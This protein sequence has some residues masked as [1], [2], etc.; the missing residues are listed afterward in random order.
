MKQWL[1]VVFVALLFPASSLHAESRLTPVSIGVSS[2]HCMESQLTFVPMNVSPSRASLFRP[3]KDMVAVLLRNEDA[4]KMM[5]DF[6]NRPDASPERYRLDEEALASIL[7]SLRGSSANL[8]EGDREI[9]KRHSKVALRHLA[10]DP[11]GHEEAFADE[12]FI[13]RLPNAVYMEVVKASAQLGVDVGD[14]DVSQAERLMRRQYDAV[15]S[16]VV[17]KLRSGTLNKEERK[18]YADAFVLLADFSRYPLKMHGIDEDEYKRLSSDSS[19]PSF[20]RSYPLEPLGFL[21][22]FGK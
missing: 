8:S 7:F 10:E 13:G 3:R 14:A 4:L 22:A 19:L 9:L 21:K 6:A 2:S 11:V 15:I 20:I 1:P 12:S 17:W 16:D 18:R 5:R